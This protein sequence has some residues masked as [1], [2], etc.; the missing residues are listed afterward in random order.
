MT[1]T[2]GVVAAD[3]R[4]RAAGREWGGERA[5]RAHQGAGPRHLLGTRAAQTVA[6]MKSDRILKNTEAHAAKCI[7]GDVGHAFIIST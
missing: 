1:M 6:A 3:G 5:L 4:K 2:R 7:V